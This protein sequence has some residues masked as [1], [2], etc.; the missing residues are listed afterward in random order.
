[1]YLT[2]GFLALLRSWDAADSDLDQ[3]DEEG[4][5]EKLHNTAPLPFRDYLR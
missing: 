3:K 5:Q 2:L 4:N 1:M